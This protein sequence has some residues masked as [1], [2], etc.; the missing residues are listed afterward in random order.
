MERRRDEM[1]EELKACPFCGSNLIEKES[2][3]ES[4]EHGFRYMRCSICSATG[5]HVHFGKDNTAQDAWNDRPAEDALRA[6]CNI[7][8]KSLKVAKEFHPR[9]MKLIEKKKNF[10]VVACDEPYYIEIYKMIRQHEK[11]N[12]TWTDEDERNFI[13]ALDER[14]G[15]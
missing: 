9:A 8:T 3:A 10:L 15:E 1:S 2:I 12:C 4:K 6:E 11:E 14:D 7:L 5:K 13:Y